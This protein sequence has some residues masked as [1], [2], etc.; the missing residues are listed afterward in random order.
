MSVKL[1]NDPRN[2]LSRA[3]IG[4]S[5]VVS[6]TKPPSKKEVV[7]AEGRLERGTLDGRWY[8][9]LEPRKKGR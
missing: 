2:Y 7:E 1:K 4:G 9:Q 3:R 6:G 8:I 5:T